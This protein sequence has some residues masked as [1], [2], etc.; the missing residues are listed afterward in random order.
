[1]KSK[2]KTSVIP[3]TPKKG[4]RK[5]QKLVKIWNNNGGGDAS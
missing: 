4:K 5:R 1:M 2:P 3:F